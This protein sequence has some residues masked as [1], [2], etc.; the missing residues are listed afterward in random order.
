MKIAITC[1]Q[2]VERRPVHQLVQMACKLFP[3]AV[4]YTL[5]HQKGK[6]LGLL[7][8]TLFEVHFCR[9]LSRT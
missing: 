3:S 2:L 1:D 9:I 8:T 4:V 5:V 7:S 6:V